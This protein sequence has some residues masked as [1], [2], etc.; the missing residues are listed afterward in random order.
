MNAAP[1]LQLLPQPI[2]LVDTRTL[3]QGP[4]ASGASRC[5]P[6]AGVGGIP[7]DA[8]AVVLNV[9]AVGYGTQG[10]VTVYPSG[11]SVPATSTR[12]GPT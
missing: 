11:Q 7:A 6:I 3:G 8:A 5:F 9:T 4:I 1:P 2:R 10:W 12:L